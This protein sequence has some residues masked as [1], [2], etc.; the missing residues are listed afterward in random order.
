M[1]HQKPIN[2]GTRIVAPHPLT[3][4]DLWNDKNPDEREALGRSRGGFTTKIVL[5]GDSRA[6]PLSWVTLAGQRHDSFAF[7]QVMAGIRIL[8]TGPGRPRTTP[9]T[10]VG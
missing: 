2:C 3:Q 6:R 8:R 1:C 10:P 7:E 5:A 4:G 9:G